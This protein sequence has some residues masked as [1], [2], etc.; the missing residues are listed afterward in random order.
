VRVSWDAN[1]DDK[2]VAVQNLKS[3][4]NETLLSNTKSLVAEERRLTTA[5]LWSLHEIQRR[6]LYAER[7]YGSL[8]EYAV[9][10]LAYSEAAAGRRIAAMRLLVEVPEI[11]PALK[12]GS[13]NLSTLS[14][15]QTFI[16]RKES[17]SQSRKRRT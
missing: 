5:V 17:P 15:I 1:F 3:L 13:V 6:R 11:E 16:Q 9:K 2:T 7:G 12:D 4:S 8:F 14:T 10:E